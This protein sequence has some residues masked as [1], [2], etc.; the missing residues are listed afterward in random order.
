MCV[1]LS[2]I[3][4]ESEAVQV[5]DAELHELARRDARGKQKAASAEASQ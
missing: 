2:S 5:D 4:R 1:C 3:F